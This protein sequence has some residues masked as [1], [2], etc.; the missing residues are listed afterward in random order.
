MLTQCSKLNLSSLNQNENV[1][2]NIL[3]L[4]LSENVNLLSVN[5]SSNVESNLLVL[6]QSQ[7]ADLSMLK[8]N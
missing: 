6:N 7:K 3:K 1:E 4:H 5:R 8:Q 2:S